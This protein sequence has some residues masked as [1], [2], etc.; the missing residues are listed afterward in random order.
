MKKLSMAVLGAALLLPMSSIYAEIHP[1]QIEDGATYK[2]VDDNNRSIVEYHTF[3][4]NQ[5]S[6]NGNQCVW[7]QGLEEVSCKISASQAVSTTKGTQWAAGG[8]Q[9]VTGSTD[10]TTSFYYDDKVKAFRVKRSIWT[11]SQSYGKGDYRDK[12][13]TYTCEKALKGKGS[14]IKAQNTYDSKPAPVSSSDDDIGW[15]TV[16]LSMLLILLPFAL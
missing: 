10:S 12:D 7:R 14:P 8:N 4:N 15:G 2:C 3:E 1:W 9:N 6:S 11:I 13:S 5:W 16:L